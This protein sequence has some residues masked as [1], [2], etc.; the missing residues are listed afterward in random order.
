[1]VSRPEIQKF[2][3]AII[4]MNAKEGY[5]VTTDYFSGPASNYVLDKTIRLVD[6]PRLLDLIE[7]VKHDFDIPHAR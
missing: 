3:S 5:F 1:M 6:L 2:H 4:D 7:E